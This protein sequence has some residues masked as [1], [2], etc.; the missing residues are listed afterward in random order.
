MLR[1]S[2]ARAAARRR[3]RSEHRLLLA[4]IHRPVVTHSPLLLPA[5]YSLP[6][7]MPYFVAHLAVSTVSGD[8]P[9]GGGSDR[10][11][12]RHGTGPQVLCGDGARRARIRTRARQPR[13]VRRMPLYC[14]SPMG[15]PE[16][17][18]MCAHPDDSA[19]RGRL[20]QSARTNQV[21]DRIRVRD[22]ALGKARVLGGLWCGVRSHVARSHSAL[23]R[24][25]R[26]NLCW[27]RRVSVCILPLECSSC[28]WR[29]PPGFICQSAPLRNHRRQAGA[30]ALLGCLFAR[31]LVRLL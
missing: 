24:A 5:Y 8:Q 25:L 2:A 15:Y 23:D 11:A 21:S 6:T 10:L 13:A 19:V 27:R 14:S 7:P 28:S 26:C 17:P 12:L 31:A 4:V 1:C 3:C 16:Y 29:A 22:V 9:A 20:R 18:T 30:S